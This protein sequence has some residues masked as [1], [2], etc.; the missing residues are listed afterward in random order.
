MEM[1]RKGWN[2][3]QESGQA[4]LFVAVALVG[5][6]AMLGL[7]LDGGN[8]Y[9]QRRAMQNAADAGALAGARIM[10][11]DGTM[12]EAEAEA[13]DYAEERNGALSSDVSF[14]MEVRKITV[15]AH[16]TTDMTFARVIGLRD[17]DV[18]AKASASY[19]SLMLGGD[20]GPGVLAPIALRACPAGEQCWDYVDDPTQPGDAEP[21]TI[22]DDDTYEGPWD[23]YNVAGNN[24]GWLNLDCRGYPAEGQTLPEGVPRCATAGASLLTEWMLN[25]YPDPV[26]FD[27][28]LW[29]RGDNGVKAR[30]VAITEARIGTYMAIPIFDD[31]PAGSPGGPG[32][33]IQA[34]YPG[35]TYYHI[36]DLACF[37]VTGVQAT[38]NPKGLT[39]LFTTGCAFAGSPGE[40]WDSAVRTVFLT[41]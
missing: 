27:S 28:Y 10:A 37:Y 33:A 30:P 5:L 21:T 32:E 29:I 35:D 8:I 24:R 13:R 2:D 7:V 6:L 26:S 1:K 18:S 34:L 12:P 17:V 31:V 3:R 39:G 11:F 36:V 41:E 15:V 23:A 20:A 38:G 40:G 19:A 16:T 4:L 14:D 25:G 22:W 9:R